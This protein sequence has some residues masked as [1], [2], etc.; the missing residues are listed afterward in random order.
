MD[1]MKSSNQSM[2]QTKNTMTNM[3]VAAKFY[4]MTV[5]KL[6]LSERKLITRNH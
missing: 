4:S 6:V 1:I 3:K 2:M 5:M